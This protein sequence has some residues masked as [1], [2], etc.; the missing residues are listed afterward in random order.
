MSFLRAVTPWSSVVEFNCSINLQCI[1]LRY[2]GSF[3]NLLL[4]VSKY[5]YWIFIF[6]FVVFRYYYNKV[7]KLSS[8]EKPVEL[9]TP[10]EVSIAPICCVLGNFCCLLAKEKH[11]LYCC[12]T[13]LKLL[14]FM[15]APDWITLKLFK[16]VLCPFFFSLHVLPMVCRCHGKS[17]EYNNC[18]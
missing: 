5:V 16:V 15:D 14:S 2:C 13:C 18:S 3:T 12:R 17:R 9:M 4:F 10:I 6:V 1:C 7:T 8:W 11:A